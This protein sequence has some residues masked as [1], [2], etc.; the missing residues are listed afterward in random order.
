M[1]FFSDGSDYIG[2]TESVTFQPGQTLSTVQVII[3]DDNIRE[4]TQNFFAELTTTD[5][6]VNIFE[7]DATAEIIDEDGKYF[8]FL[9]F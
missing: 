6:S 5:R 7:P 1:C 9:N 2:H 3:V 4:G 8:L